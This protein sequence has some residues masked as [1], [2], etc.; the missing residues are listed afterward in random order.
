MTVDEFKDLLI[1]SSKAMLNSYKGKW[2]DGGIVFDR[3]FISEAVYSTYFNR[4]TDWDVLYKLWDW[5]ADRD[6]MIILCHKTEYKKYTDDHVPE[7][8]AKEILETYYECMDNMT[9]TTKKK[10]WTLILDTT[11]ENLDLQIKTIVS[12]CG[13]IQEVT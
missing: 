5:Y 4:K 10:I 7:E 9:I 2:G 6:T 1:L 8:A 12:V 3:N 11:D 13:K